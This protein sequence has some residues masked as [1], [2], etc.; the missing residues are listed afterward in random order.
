MTNDFRAIYPF[1]SKL[2]LLAE[3]LLNQ[4]YSNRMRDQ[5]ADELTRASSSIL[6][7]LYWSL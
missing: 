6:I 3:A 1:I 5:N 4:N 7:G 2:E